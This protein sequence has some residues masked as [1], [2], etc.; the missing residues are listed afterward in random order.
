SRDAWFAGY[1]QG[2]VA[3]SWAGF[4]ELKV[5]TEEDEESIRSF[6]SPALL[7]GAGAA[8]PIW[9]KFFVQA[10]PS[11]LEDPERDLESSFVREKIDRRTGLK[12]KATCPE[13]AVYEE[14]FL[15]DTAP[16]AECNIH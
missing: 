8:L 11:K 7:T 2:L 14:I 6:K 12:A 13:D 10:R 4:D 9:G 16:S 1:S 15:P 3:V 5:P